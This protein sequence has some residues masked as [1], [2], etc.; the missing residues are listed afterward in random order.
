MYIS[1]HDGSPK[2][3]KQEMTNANALPISAD[4]Q[5]RRKTYTLMHM[6]TSNKAGTSVTHRTSGLV[7][8]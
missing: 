4:A 7:K 5:T 2:T 8:R 3:K 1:G 6:H